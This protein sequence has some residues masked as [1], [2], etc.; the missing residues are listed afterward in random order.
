MGRTIEVSDETYEAIKDQLTTDE[1]KEILNM[2]EL[3]GETYLFQCARYIYH[4]E[5]AFVNSDYLTLKNASV[6]F[7]TGDYSSS[8]AEDK[9]SLP[10]GV[11]IMRDSIEAFY[12]LAW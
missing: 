3:V 5:V 1:Q 11:K 10:N 2:E 12:K 4:G 7:N 9:Q 8:Q 6:V